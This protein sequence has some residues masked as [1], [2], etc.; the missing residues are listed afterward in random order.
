VK[1]SL[2][3]KLRPNSANKLAEPRCFQ[4]NLKVW[5]KRT[6]MALVPFVLASKTTAPWSSRHQSWAWYGYFLGH[7]SLICFKT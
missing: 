5:G 6:V 7:L 4:Q 1:A 3:G 2:A